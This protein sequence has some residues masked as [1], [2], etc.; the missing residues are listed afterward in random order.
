VNQRLCFRCDEPGGLEPL[1]PYEAGGV[2]QC[3]HPSCMADLLAEGS[4]CGDE[5][6]DDDFRSLVRPLSPGGAP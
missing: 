3:L 4:C 1:R 6:E 2:V 5:E